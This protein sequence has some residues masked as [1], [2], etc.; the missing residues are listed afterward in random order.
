MSRQCTTKGCRRQATHEIEIR[1]PGADCSVY[2][3]CDA[4]YP[5]PG[6][7]MR[8]VDHVRRLPGVGA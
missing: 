2:Y 3:C 5:P 7:L 1:G 6:V 4:H 8:G